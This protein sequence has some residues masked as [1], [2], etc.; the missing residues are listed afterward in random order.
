[1]I[2]NGSTTVVA[3]GDGDVAI[4]EGEQEAFQQVGLEPGGLLRPKLNL[5]NLFAA[6]AAVQVGL[7]ATLAD[8]QEE[9]KQVLADCFGHGSEQAAFLLEAVCTE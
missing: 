4:A 2:T 6:A 3:A 9:G 1:L 7:A 8:K 5:G